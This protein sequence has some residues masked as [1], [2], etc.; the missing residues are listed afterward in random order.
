MNKMSDAKLGRNLMYVLV[1]KLYGSIW[2]LRL[3]PI[4]SAAKMKRDACTGQL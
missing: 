4:A 3:G 2:S 1:D